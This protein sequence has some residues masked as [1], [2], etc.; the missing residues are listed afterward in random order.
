MRTEIL[1][2]SPKPTAL[3]TTDTSFCGRIFATTAVLLTLASCAVGPNV[4]A[5]SPFWTDN[6]PA[7]VMRSDSTIGTSGKHQHFQFGRDLP[8]Q[9]WK[10]FASPKLNEL[11]DA[12]ISNYPDIAAQ[13]AALRAA[14]EEVRAQRGTLFPQVQGVGEAIREKVSGA[15]IEPGFPS[16][17]TNVFQA[18]VDVSY[19]FDLFGGERRALERL[20]AQAL[21]QNFRLEASYL[22]LTTNVAATAIHIAAV[23]DAI[24]ATEEIIQV[25]ER[26]LRIIERKVALG[27]QTRADVLQQQA[28][29]DSSRA[30][31]PTLRQE[32]MAAEHELAV[33]TGVA[34]QDAAPV[35]LTLSDLTMP[36]ELPISLPSALTQQRPDIRAQEAVVH[37]AGAAIGVATADLLP[38]LTLRGSYG[39]ESLRFGNLLSPGA[40]IWNVSAGITQPLFAGGT[41]R[42]RRRAAIDTYEQTKAQYRLVVLHAFQD[43]ADT[44]NALEN[45]A[46]ASEAQS[47][48][49]TAAQAGVELIRKQYDDGAANYVSLLTAQQNYQQTR[50][51]YL[52][53]VERRYSDTVSLFQALGGGWWNRSDPGIL[54]GTSSA[55]M[56]PRPND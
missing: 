34:P 15:S 19:A 50:L 11:I 43:V 22:T 36:E 42:A 8:G 25:E 33:L 53:A 47:D 55:K 51:A 20:Q 1:V 16:F 54:Q 52:R 12:A 39:A 2:V 41:L 31:L 21:M 6:Y 35:Q 40:S 13:Q 23:H 26:Q 18:H 14:I 30:M 37:Q 38:Q 28:I 46:Q 10:L 27:S 48:A 9:W 3:T 7:E 17:I 45:D 49:L 32:L 29:L 56:P 4:G 5:P 24:A 44:L